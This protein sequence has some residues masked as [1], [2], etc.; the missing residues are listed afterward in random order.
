MLSLPISLMVK[1]GFILIGTE[2]WKDH[3]D[4]PKCRPSP[5]K[6]DKA[7]STSRYLRFWVFLPG[8]REKW[9][10]S[11]TGPGVASGGL[12]ASPPVR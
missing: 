5:S 4:K 2:T 9:L 11:G 6:G 1:D 3:L 10:V 7:M 12:L 8:A